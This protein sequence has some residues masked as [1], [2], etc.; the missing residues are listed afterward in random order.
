MPSESAGPSELVRS[1]D[2]EWFEVTEGGSLRQCDI[3]LKCPIL[4]P[5]AKLSWP[6]EPGSS[7]S[8][9]F[10]LYDTIVMTQS[11]DLDNDKV[12]DV[13]LAQVIDYR[14]LVEVEAKRGN[15]S[16]NSKGFRKKLIEGNTPGQALLYKHESEPILNWSIISFN[17]LFTI[18]K[19]FLVDYV[20]QCGLRLRVLSPYR[21]HV[22]QAFAR[23]VMRV[24]L[25]YD[26]R[27]FETEG[28]IKGS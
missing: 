10:R 14:T 11:C 5:Q 4:R 13:L 2:S 18:D 27:A 12:E 6:I 21:E 23:F 1:R 7:I 22:A 8:V 24:G 28:E 25:P 26:A 15:T 19:Q 17:R 20:N 9:G 16:V 3:I